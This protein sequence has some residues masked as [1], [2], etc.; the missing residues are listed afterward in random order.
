MVKNT[1]QIVYRGVIKSLGNFV[2]LSDDGYN[3][4]GTR[5]GIVERLTEYYGPNWEKDIEIQR[6]QLTETRIDHR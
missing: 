4:R 2:N 5:E 3:W 1:S 6:W